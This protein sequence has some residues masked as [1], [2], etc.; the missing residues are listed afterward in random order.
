MRD[1]ISVVMGFLKA[2]DI[3]LAGDPFLEI[4]NWERDTDSIDFEFCFPIKRTDSMP[5]PPDA[6]RFRSTRELAGIKATYKGNYRDSYKAWYYLLERA[7]PD[8]REFVPHPVEV[9][10][11]DPHGGTDPLKWKAIIYLPLKHK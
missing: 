1:N 7:E 6:I 8:N 9:F 10:L 5:S 3:P 11:N 2:N 4:T